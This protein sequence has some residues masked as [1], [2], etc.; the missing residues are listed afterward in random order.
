MTAN[1][2]LNLFNEITNNSF[3]ELSLKYARS[4]EHNP[5][6]FLGAF[7]SYSSIRMACE[8]IV[9]TYKHIGAYEEVLARKKDFSEWVNKQ[10]IEEKDKQTLNSTLM[11][12]NS[13]LHP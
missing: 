3:V 1:D 8:W 5:K 4:Y 6:A 10:D 2:R 13:I 12:I 11:I 9:Y 7:K